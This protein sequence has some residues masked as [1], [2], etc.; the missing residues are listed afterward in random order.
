M[1]RATLPHYLTRVLGADV[2]S[3]RLRPEVLQHRLVT[4]VGPGG[5]GK[6]RLAVE[7]AHGL[8]RPESAAF[9]LVAFVPLVVCTS[10]AQMLDAL[11]AAFQARAGGA[12]AI[13]RLLPLL[14]GR[15]ALLVLDNF[16]QLGAD[17]AQQV[18]RLVSALPGLHLLL[19]S[20][21]ALGLDGEREFAVSALGLPGA[22]D[23]LDA[24]AG[25]PA[26]ALFVDRARAVRSDFHLHRGNLQAVK[27]LVTA[28]DGMPLA[29]ELAAA[30]VR[31]IALA[32]MLV[33]LTEPVPGQNSPVLDLL[34]RASPRAGHDPRNASMQ[35]VI[36]WSWQ[37]L[38][39][40]QACLLA[41]LTVF[42]G[43]CTGQAADAVCG[44]AGHDMALLL[45]VRPGGQAWGS[46]AWG[47]G[48]AFCV[49]LIAKGKT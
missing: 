36:A 34:S 20:R 30:R 11:L 9:D 5:S 14:A 46:Q 31:S 3:Q 35:A 41:G 2:Q 7:L 32:Q 22:D 40:P 28:L 16:E 49:P 13:D 24:A 44:Q 37:Q 1:A 10:A 15:R 47:S 38:S 33:R 4:L 27:T 43:G 45:D 42:A 6:T 48:L 29:L 39:P 18:A 8:A 17:A 23:S 19:T 25:S 26:V 12:D 21:R